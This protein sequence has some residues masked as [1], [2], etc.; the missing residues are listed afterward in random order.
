MVCLVLS[1]SANT[2]TRYHV[3]T[4]GTFGGDAHSWTTACNDLQLVINNAQKG[5]TI[6]VAQ[7]T[8]LPNRPAN[9]LNSIVP[10]DRYNAFTIK[11]GLYLYGGF[12]GTETDLSQR[13]QFPDQGN[14]GL[15]TLSGNIG[16]P[17]DSL[18]NAYH[19][20]LVLTQQDTVLFDG[21][22]ITESYG[23]HVIPWIGDFFLHGNLIPKY[24]GG[25]IFCIGTT[26]ILNHTTVSKNLINRLSKF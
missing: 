8:Y 12:T 15:T 13:P 18:D 20:V 3:S 14:N 7:G 19:V 17:N 1:F 23:E 22:T 24:V 25:G 16:N 26:L 6:W 5:D 21:F 2:Q 9:N 10:N 4:T 11:K